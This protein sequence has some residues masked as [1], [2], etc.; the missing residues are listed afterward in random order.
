MLRLGVISDTHRNLELMR[1]AAAELR[2]V[3]RVSLIIHLGD[4]LRDALELRR[5]GHAVRAVPGTMCPGYGGPDSILRES[6]AGVPVV[7]AHTPDDLHAALVP[8]TRLA[9]HGHTHA[10]F[11]EQRGGTI[12]LNPGH[13]KSSLDRGH[14]PSYALLEVEPGLINVCIQEPGGLPRQTATYK[15]PMESSHA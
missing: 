12:W 8:D 2:D 1:G 14:R 15:L 5:D 13:L 7:C 9:M 4:Y 6:L 3:H 10:A 11:V